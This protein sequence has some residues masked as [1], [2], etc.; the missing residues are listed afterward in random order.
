[1]AK[2][3]TSEWSNDIYPC[4]NPDC[5]FVGSLDAFSGGQCY[6]PC[7]KCG[8]RREKRTGRFV[9]E[10]TPF[11]WFPLIW[12]WRFVDVEWHESSEQLRS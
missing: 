5:D 6:Y 1:M 11:K 7:Q 10:K 12:Y 2:R 4:S 9:Y 8:A 3:Y